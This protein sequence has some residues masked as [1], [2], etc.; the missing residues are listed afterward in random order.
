MT[1]KYKLGAIT[2]VRIGNTIWGLGP[3]NAKFLSGSIK[4]CWAPGL[5]DTILGPASA[6]T[7]CVPGPVNT[8]WGPRLEFKQRAED[9]EIQSPIRFDNI[10]ARIC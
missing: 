2:G 9:Q 6:N 10:Y 8:S 3:V 1:G 5:G 4:T 7:N